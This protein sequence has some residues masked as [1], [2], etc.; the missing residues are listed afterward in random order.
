VLNQL[1]EDGHVYYP[2]E[3]LVLK[4]QKILGVE[5]DI[6]VNA[7]ASISQDNRIVIEDL[8]ETIDEFRKNNKAKEQ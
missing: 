5:R 2:Y 7:F 1:A 6:I 3:P 8:N 4:C